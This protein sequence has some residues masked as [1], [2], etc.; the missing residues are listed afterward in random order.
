MIMNGKRIILFAAVLLAAVLTLGAQ[1]RLASGKVFDSDA[2]LIDAVQYMEIGHLKEARSQ[3]QAITSLDPS[4][5]AAWYYLGICEFYRKDFRE[6]QKAFLKAAE[7]DSANYWYRDRLAIA[8]SMGGE[9]ELTLATYEQMLRD[10]PKKTEVYYN[11]A[12]LYM[13]QGKL[14]KA[15]E[16]MDQI[17]TVFGRN[18]QVTAVKYDILLRQDKPAEALKVLQDYNAIKASERVLAIL[19]DH[20]MA[21]Y[22]DSSALAYYSEALALDPDYPPALLGKAEVFRARRDGVCRQRECPCRG[23]IALSERLAAAFRR[24]FYPEFP[25]PAGFAHRPG[26]VPPSGRQLPPVH[27]RHVLFRN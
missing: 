7:L 4:R 6:A 19:G 16:A 10:F 12:N 18:D 8:Y 1:G 22:R 11:L 13:R 23:Q 15:L 3:L 17:E 24:A 26:T 9:E 25:C 20:E 27:R 21:E 5:D 14:D 2:A